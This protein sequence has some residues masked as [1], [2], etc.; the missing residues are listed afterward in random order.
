MAQGAWKTLAR[1]VARERGLFVGAL[2]LAGV[3]LFHRHVLWVALIGLAVI[4]L[5]KLGFT[6]FKTGAGLPGL[7]RHLL[8]EWV[9]LT[10]LLGLLL[11]FALLSNHFEESKIPAVLPHY[12]PDGWKGAFVL[13]VMIFVLSG[14]LDNIAAA[15]MIRTIAT[16]AQSTRP[17][18]FASLMIGECLCC[19]SAA[20]MPKITIATAAAT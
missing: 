12:L 11:G 16:R 15:R 7:G 14:F 2:I 18:T 13:L 20:G 1:V 3:A 10:N 8:H 17:S 9:I 6:G 4:T 5:Y 19:C